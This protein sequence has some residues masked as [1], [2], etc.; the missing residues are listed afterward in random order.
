MELEAGLKKPPLGLIVRVTDVGEQCTKEGIRLWHCGVAI[1]HS[2]I[3]FSKILH[4]S[5]IIRMG[6]P[7]WELQDIRGTGSTSNFLVLRIS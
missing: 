1:H 5:I 3:Y 4:R 7:N 2:G 6:L